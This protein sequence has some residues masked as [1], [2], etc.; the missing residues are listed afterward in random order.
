MAPESSLVLDTLGYVH[1][2][3][4]EFAQA[5]P[6]FRKAAALAGSPVV[7]RYHLGMTYYR[8]GR[9]DDAV[10]TLRQALQLDPRSPEAVEARRVLEE[11]TGRS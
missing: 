10:T 8:L 9:R 2:K 7:I 11:L 6:L 3:R 4:G 1:F 5:E